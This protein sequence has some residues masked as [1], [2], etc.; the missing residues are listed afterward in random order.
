MPHIIVTAETSSGR[1]VAMLAERVPVRVLDA[2]G[3]TYRHAVRIAGG[4][5]RRHQVRAAG[6]N[7]GARV[8]FV[9]RAWW[10]AF[11]VMGIIVIRGLNDDGV[12][13]LPACRCWLCRQ[14]QVGHATA[15]RLAHTQAEAS[16]DPRRGWSCLSCGKWI[17]GAS[18]DDDPLCERCLAHGLHLSRPRSSAR[19]SGRHRP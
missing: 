11:S 4:V 5:R 3:A 10:P 18:G 9:A 12:T 14:G 13:S 17:P 1:Q 8:G 2:S 16:A 19:I 15:H 6:P 7:A